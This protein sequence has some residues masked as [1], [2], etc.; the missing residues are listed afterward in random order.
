VARPVAD[1]IERSKASFLVD[2]A[3]KNGGL[4]GRIALIE[5]DERGSRSTIELDYSRRG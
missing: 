5:I 1:T 3:N 4:F 2:T